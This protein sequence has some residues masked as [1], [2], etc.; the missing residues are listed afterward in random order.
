M[1]KLC[2][3]LLFL[4]LAT[5]GTGFAHE[6]SSQFDFKQNLGRKIPGSSRFWDERAHPV[7]I[8]DYFGGGPLVLVMGYFTCPN[9]CDSA[10]A[11]VMES[12]D[13]AELMAGR[14][15]RGLFVSID[16]REGPPE[17]AARKQEQVSAASS[18]GWSFL[19]GNERASRALADAIGFPYE[20]DPRENE[21]VHPA[22]FVVVSPSGTVSRYFPGM[23]FE[24]EEVRS[25]LEEASRGRV[26]SLA[27]RLL[28]L[29]THFDPV[30]GQYGSVVWNI[31]R[32][33][34]VLFALGLV[35]ALFRLKTR[36]P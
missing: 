27:D 2:A 20:Y 32:A 23:R 10:L 1:R 15:Y 6:D 24:A 19:T 7:K 16:P 28:L 14:D 4:F 13:G 29:C 36:K 12:L 22:G 11:G 35:F 31:T 21:Y 8:G 18:E 30:T 5:A 25:A 26:G 9:L 3:C 17:A 34:V 33:L